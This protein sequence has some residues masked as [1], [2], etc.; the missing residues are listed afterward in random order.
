MLVVGKILEAGICLKQQLLI[1]LEDSLKA[2][3]QM[4]WNP[5]K[6]FIWLQVV[7]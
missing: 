7:N 2:N 3:V 6:Y 1:F 5:A 4:D